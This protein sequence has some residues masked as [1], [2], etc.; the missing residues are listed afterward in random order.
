MINVGDA[1]IVYED[2]IL[3][4]DWTPVESARW[5]ASQAIRREFLHQPV[6]IVRITA[7]KEQIR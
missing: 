7:L 4:F 5:Y 1:R 3:S 2:G 6:V